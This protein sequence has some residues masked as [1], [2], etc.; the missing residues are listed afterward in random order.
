LPIKE[1]LI[2][3]TGIREGEVRKMITR[4]LE[5]GLPFTSVMAHSD[6]MAYEVLYVLRGYF[7]QIQVTGCD[8]IQEKLMIPLNFPSVD[9]TEDEAQICVQILMK[10]ILSKNNDKPVARILDV[11]LKIPCQGT[12][13]IP[14]NRH[15]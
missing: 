15:N 14:G 7:P 2:R 5:E 10:K 9:S 1:A 8:N 3:I 6:I 4:I 13:H 11:E 12:D